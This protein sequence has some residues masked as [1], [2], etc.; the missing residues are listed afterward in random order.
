MIMETDVQPFFARF[1]IFILRPFSFDFATF[2]CEDE[3][4][5]RHF[6]LERIVFFEFHA[7][8]FCLP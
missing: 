1:C 2:P 3:D 7:E 5:A 8:H 4:D 6:E